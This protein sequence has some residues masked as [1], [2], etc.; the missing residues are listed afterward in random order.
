MIEMSE[1]MQEL[2]C[3][4]RQ[5][6]FGKAEEA[7]TVISQRHGYSRE[8]ARGRYQATPHEA[9]ELDTPNVVT[10]H[11]LPSREGIEIVKERGWLPTWRPAA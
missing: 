5:K 9:T 1:L 8:I 4:V 10:I 11:D 7:L 6:N 2:A 3:A